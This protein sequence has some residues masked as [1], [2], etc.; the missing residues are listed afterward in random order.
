MYSAPS[1]PRAISHRGLCTRAPE[2]SIPAFNAAIEAGAEGVEL[3]V[4][5]S[6]DGTLFV[7][8]DSSVGGLNERGESFEWTIAEVDAHTLS[9]VQLAPGVSVPTLDDVLDAIDGRVDIFIEI[10]AAGIESAVARCLKRHADCLDR[11]AV[12]AFD[13]RI[14]KRMLE[15]LPLRTGILQRSYAVDPCAVM[16]AAGAQDL[17]QHADFVDAALV[18]NVR[19]CGGRVIAWTPNSPRQ[20]DALAKMGVHGI[21]TDRVDDYKRH[22]SNRAHEST[23]R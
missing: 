8:H 18:T 14:V 17:W 19:A 5:G 20:W 15:L 16:R 21:C 2:N 9:S 23:G 1:L 12:H 22:L 7:H 11:C 13:H 3:D 6:R 10:K 4:H